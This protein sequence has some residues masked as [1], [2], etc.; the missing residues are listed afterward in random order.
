MFFNRKE[1][2]RGKAEEC[3][4]FYTY[5]P[6]CVYMGINKPPIKTVFSCKI[7]HLF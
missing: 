3:M 1:L 2:L 4:S 7:F 6:V 5:L